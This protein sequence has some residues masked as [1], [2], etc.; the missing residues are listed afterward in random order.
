MKGASYR[1][2]HRLPS[3]EADAHGIASTRRLA[4]H[5][6]TVRLISS[7][8][9][10]M[11]YSRN[12]LMSAKGEAERALARRRIFCPF[13]LQ[14]RNPANGC[15]GLVRQRTSR[16]ASEASKTIFGLAIGKVHHL[17]DARPP[18]ELSDSTTCYLTLFGQ[19]L[20]LVPFPRSLQ[21]SVALVIPRSNMTAASQFPIFSIGGF[22]RRI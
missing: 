4:K 16:I 18:I 20:P 11:I 5:L 6:A 8:H 19:W 9:S 14:S 10:H 21:T 3:R 2:D 17:T 1:F 15:K 22:W 12:C 7:C 13:W